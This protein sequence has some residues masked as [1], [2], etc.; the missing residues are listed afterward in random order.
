MNEGSK[1]ASDTTA[2]EI[3]GRHPTRRAPPNGV[4]PTAVAAGPIFDLTTAEGETESERFLAQLC[5]HSFLSLWSYPNTFT[6]EGV[7]DDRT[8]SGNE[9]A[10]VLVVF[11]DDVIIFSDKHIRFNDEVSLDVAWPRWFKSAITK[12]VRQLYG[13][14]NWAKRFPVRVYQDAACK[15]PLPVPLP[16]SDRARFHLVATTR[17]SLGPCSKHF[18]GS[19]G[20]HQINTGIVG[21][22][23]H[24]HPFT[25]GIVE[26][27]KKFVHVFD[28]FSLE[29]VLRERD[30]AADFIAY[31]EAREEFLTSGTI[32]IAAGEEQLLAAYMTN[33]RGGEHWFL[34]PQDGES[35]PDIIWFDESHWPGLHER[36]EYKAK[37]VAD[38]KAISGT[39]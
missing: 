28:E 20:T 11:G 33:M 18:E 10:D 8:S 37:K 34:P 5:R 3:P 12:S 32:V 6:D 16:P 17:G 22:D 25:V 7:R 31:L 35:I 9:F 23:H 1:E 29:V 4:D 15:R 38:K 27:R 24:Q 19:L 21:K 39:N 2:S 36:P 30:T 26:P 13:A 14:M